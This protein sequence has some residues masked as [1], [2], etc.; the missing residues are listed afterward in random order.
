M[1]R[2]IH[3]PL[4]GLSLGRPGLLASMLN[5]FPSE[6][7]LCS[8][9][10]NTYN[11][12]WETL[13]RVFHLSCLNKDRPEIF[14]ERC[15]GVFSLPPN[16]K[17]GV[18]PQLLS[19]MALSARL[20][21]R[22]ISAVDRFTEEQV[23]TWTDLTQKWVDDLRGKEKLNLA[24]L[25]AQLLLLLVHQNNLTA[26]V[27]LWQ[28]SGNLVRNAMVMGLHHDPEDCSGFSLFEKEQR[29]KLWRSIVE[30]EIQFSLATGMPAAIRS[31]DFNARDLLN[32]DDVDL[33]ED[34]TEYPP[35]KPQ[36]QWTD[37]TPQMV[38]G[39]SLKERLDAIN[40]LGGSIDLEKDADALLI[41][42]RD[43]ER[44]LQLLPSS[45]R[46]T[47]TSGRNGEKSPGRLFTQIMLDVFIRRPALAI[48]RTIALSPLSSRYPEAR[49]AAVQSSIAML[50]HLD[51][52]DPT[53]A[54]LNIIKDRDLLNHFHVLCKNDIIQAAIM[55]CVEIR[56]FSLVS[57]DPD[58]EEGIQEETPWT[59]H[60]LARIVDNTLS[61]LLQRVGAFG[62]DLKDILPLSVV[63][64]CARSDG[65]PEER[66]DLMRNGAERIL[67]ACRKFSQLPKVGPSDSQNG[68][69]QDTD[70][71]SFS[72]HFPAY[73]ILITTATNLLCSTIA[74]LLAG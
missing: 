35:G 27:E 23:M 1:H 29:R 10:I 41:R 45:I 21:N 24:T 51:A 7:S 64:Q 16:I 15:K 28:K 34:M 47:T 74:I 14:N 39:V 9:S 55:L 69:E 8:V 56:R 31:S 65:T 66:R 44:Y 67:N 49:R 42:A 2:E 32:V 33:S 54:D 60:S 13:I 59:K 57:R 3:P 72:S 11:T 70:V 53:V 46:S 43:L 19:L 25:K 58:S 71:V 30:V 37:S 50:S 48:Y 63:L 12:Y 26:P 61:S 73:D 68:N 22:S 4:N 18:V 20:S 40:I 52:L 62:S 38:L 36:H 6:E 17:E 5:S